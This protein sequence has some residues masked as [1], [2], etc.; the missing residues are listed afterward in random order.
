MCSGNNDTTQ[1]K[2]T[3][4][5]NVIQTHVLPAQEQNSVQKNLSHVME[6]QK[7][8]QS[9]KNNDW[10]AQ[11]Q[12]L[13]ESHQSMAS[14][15]EYSTEAYTNSVGSKQRRK[16]QSNRRSRLFQKRCHAL[17]IEQ[18]EHSFALQRESDRE[19][20]LAYLENNHKEVLDSH[21][22]VAHNI[23]LL[24]S[25][26]G[27]QTDENAK[28][29]MDYQSD[30]KAVIM[31]CLEQYM[32]TDLSQFQV[33][34]DASLIEHAEFLEKVSAQTYMLKKLITENH[35]GD[36]DDT[37]YQEQRQQFE[38]AYN[39][40]IDYVNYYRVK[41]Q[42]I[43]DPYYSTHYN[44]EISMRVSEQNTTEQKELTDLLL[45]AHK[46][47]E[48]ITGIQV[49]GEQTG[50]T[51]QTDRN[52]QSSVSEELYQSEAEQMQEG[53]SQLQSYRDYLQKRQ[54]I[55][56]K[57]M[58]GS[59]TAQELD[60]SQLK[61]KM[62]ELLD[63]YQRLDISND[64]L[65]GEDE[66]RERKARVFRVYETAIENYLIQVDRKRDQHKEDSPAVGEKNKTEL[67]KE[68]KNALLDVLAD[69]GKQ[70]LYTD[71]KEYLEKKD[72]PVSEHQ[73]KDGVLTT[74]LEHAGNLGLE[75]KE[76][77]VDDQGL[78][79]DQIEG[80]HSIDQW[81]L[82][83]MHRDGVFGTGTTKERF[84]LEMLKK[85]MRE[86][87]FIY[88]IVENGMYKS[89]N[90][91]AAFC[92]QAGYVPNLDRFKERMVATKFKFWKRRNGGQ[93]Y[94]HK[95]DLAQAFVTENQEALE[96][97][98]TVS[99]ET[100]KKTKSNAN[101]D[102]RSHDSLQD[103]LENKYKEFW[104][105]TAE[106][107]AFLATE[108]EA[109]RDQKQI[110]QIQKK[111]YIKIIQTTLREL[112][113]LDASLPKKAYYRLEDE[114]EEEIPSVGEEVAEKA[115][116]ITEIAGTV[117]DQGEWISG[118]SDIAWL[119]QWKET[120]R[121]LLT[122]LD[123]A[124]G[125]LGTLAGLNSLVGIV[126]Q[127]YQLYHN[128]GEMTGWER[129]RA[130]AELTGSLSDLTVTLGCSIS[131][132][133]HV[134][135]YVEELI[136]D[137][138]FTQLDTTYDSML[139]LMIV[140]SA[141]QIGCSTADLV[142]AVHGKKHLTSAKQLLAARKQQSNGILPGQEP[143]QTKDERYE[144]G[145]VKLVSCKL[146]SQI[147]T[148]SFGLVTG[149]ASMLG[150][151]LGYTPIA[152]L[153]ESIANVTSAGLSII[154]SGIS[155]WVEKSQREQI[156][157]D[158]LQLDA[159]MEKLENGPLE[160]QIKE[161]KSACREQVR[162]ELLAQFGFSGKT[163]F[164]DHI[165]KVYARFLYQKLFCKE[166]GETPVLNSDYQAAPEKYDPYIELVTSVGLTVEFPKKAGDL[167]RPSENLLIDK[168][169]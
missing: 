50:S 2:Q 134:G 28:L 158:F 83:N 1:I 33:R 61:K 71:Y 52:S 97:H 27:E 41:K 93:I 7:N 11:I 141:I 115:D 116:E 30:R 5:R 9:T 32:Q 129:A 111:A 26:F 31:Q 67:S 164:M 10:E 75:K 152:P 165:G 66:K 12:A 63:V 4:V 106:Y 122:N 112:L 119:F 70:S 35:F 137:T 100:Q 79:Q 49:Q 84:V 130:I 92:S 53:T 132:L 22:D 125:V 163:S 168:F 159:L 94:W 29:V 131:V 124:G 60:A 140:S 142:E 153:G 144:Q 57:Q 76:I 25:F 114:E 65:I 82:R 77:K 127:S 104:N 157:D 13:K 86:R 74:L 20:V 169:S 128:F 44:T 148:S 81:M 17:V 105:C 146:N 6:Q 150:A 107:R 121:G 99:G 68:E 39:K 48:K 78:E 47:E 73:K 24:S 16:K 95:L 45:R 102:K 103:K 109:T 101:K 135:Q 155:A 117:L 15:S 36:S 151:I 143:Q 120:S 90:V 91:S 145:I 55:S 154:F 8:L 42:I 62:E 21:I 113:E 34:D 147:M 72:L 136:N 133:T 166:D 38:D 110:M 19:L 161:D 108:E 123:L 118:D 160:Q 98:L 96:S 51:L 80:V 54:L 40:I 139:G 87:L 23:D 37:E 56:N 85:S 58:V 14:D 64:S 167:P 162:K 156:V 43:K 88:Y 18:T 89:P 46:Y 69:G 59:G 138:E 126:S 149:T 3:S